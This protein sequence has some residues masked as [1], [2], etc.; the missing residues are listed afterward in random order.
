M[1]FEELGAILRSEREKKNINITDVA[2]Q[3]KI[4]PRNLRAMEEGDVEALPHPAYV[5]GFIRS[6]ATL[7]GL[8]QEEL[9]ELMDS[10]PDLNT[11]KAKKYV[12]QKPAEEEKQGRSS[13]TSFKILVFLCILGAALYYLWDAGY[14]DFIKKLH[15]PVE[16]QSS[17]LQRA[18]SYIAAKDAEKARRDALPVLTPTPVKES[19]TERFLP[20]PGNSAIPTP[21]AAEPEVSEVRTQAS[22][23][24]NTSSPQAAVLTQNQ[25]KTVPEESSEAANSGQHK[26]IITA[27]EEC[28]IHSNAD[29]TDTRQFSLRKG[30][31]FALTFA[32]S[33][34]LKLGNAGGVRLRYDG[35]DLPPPG[36]SGQVR[37][38]TFP[39]KSNS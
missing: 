36:S 25:D 38:I 11:G 2:N 9:Q 7:L 21:P 14:L 27:V 35:N 5:R 39:P 32:D 23:E 13:R 18:D 29:K 34:E 3:L 26:L 37:T 30:D 12:P 24:E 28:W 8:G 22:L 1:T 15:S 10:I 6:Y 17:E 31:T 33:L 20:L 19:G 16:Q 4:N